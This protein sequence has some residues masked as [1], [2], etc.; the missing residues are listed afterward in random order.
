METK[1]KGYWL[2]T[3]YITWY[4]VQSNSQYRPHS[5][6]HSTSRSY[7]QSIALRRQ[8]QPRTA[9]EPEINAQR[10]KAQPD[11]GEKYDLNKKKA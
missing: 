2:L 3:T 8:H 6:N 7:T 9:H 11:I 10:E 5:L 4:I 1:L